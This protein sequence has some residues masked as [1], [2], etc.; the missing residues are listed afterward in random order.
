MF[1]SAPAPSPFVSLVPIWIFCPALL[2]SSAWTSVLATMNSTPPRPTSTMRSTAL[3]PPPPTPTTLMRAALRAS[4]ASVNRSASLLS[5]LRPWPSFMCSSVRCLKEFFEDAPKP[6]GDAAERAGAGT[7]RIGRTIAVRVQSDAHR[8]GKHRTAD[9][10]GQAAH[11][12][13]RTA[14]N[15]QIEDLLGDLGHPFENRAAAGEHD[16]RVQRL[17]ISRAANLVP[18]QVEDLFGARLQDFRQDPPRHQPRLAAADAR[19]FDRLVLVH[20]RRQGA[21]ALPLQLFRVG[22]GRAQAN[23]DVTG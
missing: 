2:W 6:T 14:S 13:G 22:N 1:G 17:L 8:R 9:V 19:H 12:D 18:Y 20:H 10:I 3:L 11:A 5:P 16:S 21:A 7:R 4:G 15:R 23:R